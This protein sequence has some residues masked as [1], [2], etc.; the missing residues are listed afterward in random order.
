M[1]GHETDEQTTV[2][3]DQA[4]EEGMERFQGEL[5]EAAAETDETPAQSDTTTPAE[6]KDKETPPVTDQA[7]EG[8]GTERE[9]PAGT[10][11]GG[12]TTDVGGRKTASGPEGPTP[13]REDGKQRT[14]DGGRRTDVGLRPRGAY[15]PEGSR[16]TDHRF[17]SHEEAEDGYRNL[18][19]AKSR[20]DQENA[21]LKAEI[22]AS[23]DAEKRQ[24]QLEKA[25]VE[26]VDFTASRHEEALKAINE[27]DP[28]EEGY[29]KQVARIWAQK[30]MAI[31]LKER[32]LHQKIEEE[33]SAGTEDGGRTTASGPEGFQAEGESQAPDETASDEDIW[34]YVSK[35]AGD[36]K[37]D[38]ND[39]FFRLTCRECPR[40]DAEGN[41]MTL[42]QQITWAIHE[43]RNYHADQERQYQERA[44]AQATVLSENR[45][46]EGLPMGRS[47]GEPPPEQEEPTRV[48][49]DDA[50]ESAIEERRL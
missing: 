36:E 20:T 11:D 21:R 34:D 24:Q 49:L 22:K 25:D 6:T 32:E 14:E 31:R 50:I 15:A 9:T 16:K 30:D 35:K 42:D 13:R 48:S 37:I 41:P 5:E 17:R 29:Q 4:M 40:N 43:T 45:Q 3:L 26:F 23:K 7:D 46:E 12:Q 39:R 27:L 2:D 19:G 47:G 18:Q 33:A 1:T 10:E 8:A 38:P 44:K 28:E